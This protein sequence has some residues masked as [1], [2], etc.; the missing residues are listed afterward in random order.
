[1][2]CVSWWSQQNCC[3]FNCSSILYEISWKCHKILLY[4][5]QQM[6]III[7]Y[8][9][10]PFPEW[11][12]QFEYLVKNIPVQYIILMINFVVIVRYIFTFHSKNP[13]AIQDDFWSA[14]LSIWVIG[15]KTINVPKWY[16]H[17]KQLLH[18]YTR[19]WESTSNLYIK[20]LKFLFNLF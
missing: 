6:L 8:L 15:N 3:S 5:F 19:F 17:R 2:H 10:G 20:I 7:R 11:L 16:L 9:I 14:F 4:P 1:M 13:T 18:M 12:C